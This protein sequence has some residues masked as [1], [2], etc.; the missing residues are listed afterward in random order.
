[1]QAEEEEESP[2]EFLPIRCCHL[3]QAQASGDVAKSANTPT[4]KGG[5]SFI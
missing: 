1:M 4:I 5:F 3:L 2:Q